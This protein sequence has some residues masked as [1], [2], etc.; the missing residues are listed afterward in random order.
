MG[1]AQDPAI[2]HLA[3][4]PFLYPRALKYPA[5]ACPMH[6][7]IS[8]WELG[9]DLERAEAV[10]INA[11]KNLPGQ[12][13]TYH[14]PCPCLPVDLGSVYFIFYYWWPWARL[15]ISVY[16][17]NR[18]QHFLG[19]VSRDK[20]CFRALFSLYTISFLLLNLCQ[21]QNRACFLG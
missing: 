10:G 2:C 7:K 15:H 11:Q 3:E 19:C 16:A 12:T 18:G 5:V 20:S 8:L 9:E 21:G 4:S 1:N 13:G 17:G 6:V 14:M